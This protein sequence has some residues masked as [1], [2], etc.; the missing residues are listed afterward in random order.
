MKRENILKAKLDCGLTVFITH[1]GLNHDEQIN[2]QR[3]LLENLENEK[4]ILMGDFNVAPTC[5]LL[6]SIRERMRDTAEL[7]SKPLL[8]YP[9][10]K[11]KEKRDYIFTSYDIQTDFA[12]IPP[13]TTS[14]H[15]P[16]IA[17]IH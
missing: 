6:N 4:C 8:S 5:E 7:F 9:S 17:K 11:P 16:Y 13:V 2:A 12:D 14:D 3:T 1:W 10:D 15:R